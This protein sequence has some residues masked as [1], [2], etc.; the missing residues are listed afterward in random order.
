MNSATRCAPVGVSRELL[1]AT[2]RSATVCPKSG[3]IVRVAERVSEH[4]GWASLR[5]NQLS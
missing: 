3:G 2:L 4:A 1:R 5:H